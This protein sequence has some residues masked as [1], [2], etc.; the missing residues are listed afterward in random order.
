MKKFN[1]NEA[2]VYE[3]SIRRKIP[4]YEAM[5]A[6]VESAIRGQPFCP[7]LENVLVIGAGTGEELGYL[8]KINE[9]LKITSVEPSGDMIQKLLEKVF[10]Q[11][12]INRVTVINKNLSD[13]EDLKTYQLITS[14]LVSHFVPTE[15]KLE[16]FQKISSHLKED[17]VVVVVDAFING[18]KNNDVNYQGWIKFLDAN[19]FNEASLKLIIENFTTKFYPLSIDDFKT[20]I[21]NS[22]MEVVCEFWQSLIFRGFVLKKKQHE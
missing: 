5:H 17:G 20:I 22:D 6:L 15:S 3:E 7:E 16:Y 12:A 18:E 9:S 11:N 19:G 14:I 13:A 4:A 21:T 2:K 1:Q 10:A 8:L